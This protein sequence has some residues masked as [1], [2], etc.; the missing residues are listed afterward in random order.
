MSNILVTAI[1]SLSA[2]ITI[3]NLKKYGHYVVGCDI[4]NKFLVVDSKKVDLFYTIPYANDINYISKLI[5]ICKDNSI[6][7]LI[8]LTDAEIDVL[9]ENI[10][11]FEANGIIVC[12]SNKSVIDICRDKYQFYHFLKEIKLEPIIKTKRFNNNEEISYPSILKPINGRSSEG[13]IKLFS[14]KDK[15]KLGQIVDT[16]NYIIQPLINGNIIT[17][18]VIVDQQSKTPVIIQREELIRNERG[19][20]LSIRLVN[21][22]KVTE[23]INNIIK[24]LQ[25][26]GAFNIEFIKDED[27]N[28]HVIEI[29]PR[30]SGGI[31]FSCIA[32]YDFVTNHLNF[33]KELPLDKP[34]KYDNLYI[35]RKYEEYVMGNEENDE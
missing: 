22:D 29:N 27:Y 3:K 34:I 25:L 35:A 26:K 10:Q 16:N 23:L 2:D 20:G 24:F 33:F 6:E 32:G 30:F 21:Y 8:P 28:F 12:I 7:Y 1:G 15:Y 14:E 18:D 17:A 13:I 4:N 31:E 19:L 5:E 9:I 11:I